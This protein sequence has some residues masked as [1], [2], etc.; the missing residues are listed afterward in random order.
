[1]SR[2]FASVLLLSIIGSTGQTAGGRA[3]N[4]TAGCVDRFDPA[5]NSVPNKLAIEDAV[6]FSVEYRRSYKVVTV[7][8][9]T[10]GGPPERYLLAQCGTPAPRLTGDL[11]GARVLT[12]TLFPFLALFP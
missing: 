10:A 8:D 2:A 11:V 7:R 5:A 12:S 4:V 3:A 9:A 1:M 6:D